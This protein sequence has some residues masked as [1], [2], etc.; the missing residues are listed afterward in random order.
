[1]SIV[2]GFIL[3]LFSA[4]LW[5]ASGPSNP[6]AIL[7]YWN[8]SRNQPAAAGGGSD[9]VILNNNNG[10]KRTAGATT[11]SWNTSAV[12][13]SGNMIVVGVSATQALGVSAVTDNC[14][15]SFTRDIVVGAGQQAAIFH[16]VV[17]SC[18]N[19]Y[20][21]TVTPDASA[22]MDASS[23]EVSNQNATPGDVGQSG[24]GTGT[25]PATGNT[26]TTSAT[27]QLAFAVFA[28]DGANPTS[29]TMPTGW[30]QLYSEGDGSVYE[31]GAGAYSLS[32]STLSS[33]AI[34]ATFSMNNSMNW[35]AAIFTFKK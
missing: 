17:G 24:T 11:L 4:P 27:T 32:N 14:S 6:G 12:P 21:I 34:G 2:L 25:A 26:A 20:T 3:A 5:A 30:T 13:T 35:V 15:T 1:M 16:G 19:P 22:A 7:Q 18:G 31:I 29:I 23:F 9:L 33:V 10:T 8:N 28:G